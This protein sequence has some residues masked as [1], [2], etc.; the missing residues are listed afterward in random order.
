MKPLVL[1]PHSLTPDDSAIVQAA[2]ELQRGG[3]VAFPT[4]TVYGLGANGLDEDAVRR[5]FE[6][7]GRPAWNPVILHV[8]DRTQAEAVCAR[9][10]TPAE[11]RVIDHYW[12]GPLTLVL[13]RADV[14]PE[15]VSAGGSTVAVRCPDHP[16]ALALIRA[17]GRPIA[18]PSANRFMGIS[19]TCADHV[20][21]SLGDRVDLILDG[22]PTTVGIES[23]VCRV[24]GDTVSILRPGGTTPAMFEAIGLSVAD[25]KS[26][27]EKPWRTNR[28]EFAESRAPSPTASPGQ[29]ERHYAPETP[30]YVLEWNDSRGGDDEQEGARRR[31]VTNALFDAIRSK[32]VVSKSLSDMNQQPNVEQAVV[33]GPRWLGDALTQSVAATNPKTIDTTL[34]F[35]GLG[36]TDAEI[37]R[38]LYRALHE[39]DR[40]SPQAI[41]FVFRAGGA[42]DAAIRD[43][44]TRASAG[45]VRL[46]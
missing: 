29:H 43:R 11:R 23:T 46:P 24:D 16:L 33:I 1:T 8:A 21:S 40:R 19:P 42:L 9:P 4:E 2:N 5:I 6:A 14:V 34:H 30:V 41:W 37:A 12:P 35:V 27:D 31:R 15:A 17:T 32:H 13:P 36:E 28:H 10:L 44:L 22:G 39:A 45:W 18:A 25:D 7:K 20:I 3:L 38:G 26:R